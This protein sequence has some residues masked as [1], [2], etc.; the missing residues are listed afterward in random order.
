MKRL[1]RI[2]LP[3][4]Q[5]IPEGIRRG[6]VYRD[7]SAFL[8]GSQRWAKDEVAAW[9]FERLREVVR[10]AYEETVYYRRVF[11]EAHFNPYHFGGLEDFRRLP[12][13]TREVVDR[14]GSTMISRKYPATALLP[15]STGG[16]TARP[17]TVFHHRKTTA[18]I[19]R[20]F[21]HHVWSKFGYRP[22]KR[23]AFLR[24]SDLS[25]Q[26]F[27]RRGRTLVLACDKL[28]RDN[29][30][31]YVEAIRQFEPGY[32][33]TYPSSAHLLAQFMLD[34]G[35]AP[36]SSLE[37]I[38]LSSENLTS[39][40]SEIIRNYFRAPICNLYGNTERTVLASN[41]PCSGA[42]HFFPEYGLVELLDENGMEV[43]EVGK[44]AAVVTTSFTNPEFPLIRY[45]TGDYVSG[46]HR[47]CT[48]QWNYKMA[49]EVDGREQ[50]YVF[51]RDSQKVPFIATV[52][53]HARAFRN[54]MQF[55][56]YQQAPG[57]VTVRVIPKSGFDVEDEAAVIHELNRVFGNT[58][59]LK[60]ERVDRMLLTP[61]GKYKFVV[62]DVLCLGQVGALQHNR[63]ASQE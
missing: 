50:A 28:R 14:L 11:N 42:L 40:Q 19:E 32:L 7:W 17:L 56:L 60:V 20:A 62:H 5:R 6:P 31:A 13:L 16:T 3:L 52:N 44:R 63:N 39:E 24:V 37:L 34:A 43:N 4:Y 53:M 10:G 38:M 22:E 1:K 48:C 21:V 2:L 58:I 35:V 49:Q 18:E 27:E 25:E 45:H 9:Q 51:T 12:I 15:A 30:V 54:V 57:S 47:E 59:S 8:E 55:Q 29:F 33:F 36:F 26:L 41:C 23:L 61:R 46:I